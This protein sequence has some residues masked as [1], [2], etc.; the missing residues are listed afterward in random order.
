MFNLTAICLTLLLFV[1]NPKEFLDKSVPDTL[2]EDF[3][4][5]VEDYYSNLYHETGLE[6]KLDYSIFRRAL[7]GIS[8]L[9]APRKDIL[10]I[11][12]Y[13]KP[14]SA[15]RFFVIDLVNGKLL[16]QTLVAHGKNS[17][18]ISCNRFS[19]REHSLQSS[20]GFFL[21]AESY[22]GRHGYSLRLDGMEPGLND[23]ARERA[24]VIHGADYVCQRYV[25]DFGY[26]GRSFGCPALPL[27]LNQTIIDLIKGGSCLYVHSS[28]KNYFDLTTICD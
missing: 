19:N 24:I 14:S 1:S 7:V 21:T 8:L 9:D 5:L 4:Y 17:G 6:G 13:T 18:E 15:R 23:Q 3:T 11:I 12:D 25:D 28:D 2:K 27:E 22:S 20:P 16:Y 10:T 26:I